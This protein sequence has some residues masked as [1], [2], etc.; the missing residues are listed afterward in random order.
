M[1]TLQKTKQTIKIANMVKNKKKTSI[2]WHPTVKDDLMNNVSDL[3]SFNN[4]YFRDRFEL[5][6]EQA[7]DI[8]VGLRESMVVEKHQSK[9]FKVK[10]HIRD[11]LLSEMNI[12]DQSENFQIEFEEDPTAYTHHMLIVGGTNS[13][14]TWFAVNQI[15]RNLDGPKGLR[16]HF[17]II[18]SEWNEDS[19]LKPLKQDKYNQFVHGVDVSEDSLKES[20]WTSRDD[21]FRNEVQLKIEHA[22]RGAVVFLDDSMDSCCPDA[23]RRLI[24]KGLRVFRHQG[25][26]LMVILH[27]IRSGAWSSQAYNSI[28]YLVL[29]PRSQK[30]KITN[31]LNQE[32]GLPL[33]VAR[34]TV[35]EFSQTGR[36]MIVRLHSPEVLIGPKL[37]K[38]L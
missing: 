14:K 9:F 35:R 24:N 1:L 29:F 13:G 23:L 27:S 25:I 17:V 5:S 10:R 4:P 26:S 16:R 37:I 12:S 8:F 19:T 31:Y 28:R 21:F 15:L 30:G 7:D 18:S 38:I 11:S 22:P 32:I 3:R 6:K 36:H 34:E 33:K 20:E 2:Y